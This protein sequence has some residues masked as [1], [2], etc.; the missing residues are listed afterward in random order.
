MADEAAK[1]P[2]P[3]DD[4]SKKGMS[5]VTVAI[6]ASAVSGALLLL[7]GGFLLKQQLAELKKSLAP[8]AAEGGEQHGKEGEK[9]AKPVN[10]Q[11]LEEFV[12]NLANPGGSRYLKAGITLGYTGEA[13]EGGGGHGHGGGSNPLKQKEPILR[14]AII[15]V[16]S[17][18]TTTELSTVAGKEQAKL[19]ILKRA[20]ELDP[21]M[22]YSAVYLTSFTM[23]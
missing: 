4:K 6:A 22:E 12:V 11:V 21:K 17:S 5:P 2:L 8:G 20:Q 14:D 3:G 10:F 19:E 18:K 23:Q 16:L 7:G 15:D 9:Q 1:P 13:P